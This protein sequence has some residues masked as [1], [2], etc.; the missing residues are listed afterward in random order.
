M[1]KGKVKWFN[2]KKG[3][4]FITDSEG[5][6]VFV[7]YSAIMC[8]GF[9]S[10]NDGDIVE[11]E[12]GEGTTGREQAVNVNPILTM[13]MITETLKNENLS[14]KKENGLYIVVDEN[15]AI[16]SSECGMS[17][18]ELVAYAGLHYPM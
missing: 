4:G 3:Y 14:V 18:E 2:N 6:D 13:Q 9:K 8:D 17:F 7:H 12:I 16:Q 10:L 5:K 11:F 1:N 15:N